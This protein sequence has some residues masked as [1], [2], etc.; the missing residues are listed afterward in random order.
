M[1]APFALALFLWLVID[2]FADAISAR[3]RIGDKQ[4]ISPPV[5]LTLAIIA[6]ALGAAVI[7]MVIA[8]TAADFAGSSEGYRERLDATIAALHERFR[9][10]LN[11]GP[12]PPSTADL[13]SELNLQAFL[14]QIASATREIVS[15]SI[16]ICIYVAFLFAAE[17]S[18]GGKA[19]AIFS[20]AADREQ[21]RATVAAIRDS[22]EQFVWVQT[23]TGAIP[24]AI[25]YVVLQ[26]VGLDQ[27]LFWAFLIF[28]VGYVPTIGPIVATLLPSMF[29]FVQFDEPWRIAAVF[30]GVAAPQ[31]IMGNIVQ[32]RIQG[33][34]LNLNT[35]VVLLGLAIWG[36]LWGIPGMFLS[37]PLMVA[38][39]VILA[40]TQSARWLAVLMSSDGKPDKRVTIKSRIQKPKP[41]PKPAP[42]PAKS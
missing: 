21:A 23:W 10:P 11:L 14:G 42:E 36:E 24:A 29:A 4:L 6:V 27:P 40:H 39:M 16:L 17:A 5:A 28:L 30:F 20:R 1:L 15:D 32:P 26:A 22:V 12:E 19:E 7:V 33:E 9:Q 38:I 25:A 31:F 34:S 3:A 13:F 2:G 8:D 18:F 35:V 37:S 41:K